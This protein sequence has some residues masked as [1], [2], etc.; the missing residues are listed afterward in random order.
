M[1]IIIVFDCFLSQDKYRGWGVLLSHKTSER[2]SGYLFCPNHNLRMNN[3]IKF[4]LGVCVV[5]QERYNPVDI[6]RGQSMLNVTVTKNSIV[7]LYILIITS[8]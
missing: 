1:I 4:K 3:H 8:K 6:W 2:P 5:R 7:L